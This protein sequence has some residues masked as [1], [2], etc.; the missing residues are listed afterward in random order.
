VSC[1]PEPPLGSILHLHTVPPN[2]AGDTLFASMYAAYEA[3]SPRLKSYLEGLTA[4]HAG[5]RNYRRNNRLRGIDDRGR[6]FPWANHPVVR[7][8]PVTGRKALYVNRVF[9]Y[10]INEVP[11]PESDAILDY[12]Y[13]HAERPEFQVRFQWKP[14]SVAFW[15]NR[16]VQH[17]AVWDYFPQVRSGNRVTIKGDRPY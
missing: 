15:D 12:L 5:E 4:L 1:D 10:R 3:L 13:R 7:T 11:E 16:A 6:V 2:G 17:L 9:T 8:H 14:N